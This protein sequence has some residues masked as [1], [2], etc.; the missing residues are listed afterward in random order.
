MSESASLH[1][2]AEMVAA[3]KFV[4][5]RAAATPLLLIA[6]MQNKALGAGSQQKSRVKR[7]AQGL[8]AGRSV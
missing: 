1:R 5:P 2:E 8:N 4:P 7:A 6:A 3:G